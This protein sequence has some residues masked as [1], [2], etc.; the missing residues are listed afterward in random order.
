MKRSFNILW[1]L[2]LALSASFVSC[3]KDLEDEGVYAKTEY[4]GKVVEKSTMQPIANVAVQ[5]TDGTHIHASSY[6]DGA[7]NFDIKNI[8]FDEVSKNYYLWLDGSQINLPSKQEPLKGLGKKVYDYKTLIL[9]DKT[10][11]SIL[12]SVSTDAINS[13]KATTATVSG[14]VSSDGGYTVKERGI[15]YATTQTPTV[16]NIKVNAGT[17]KGSFTCNLSGLTKN[18]TYYVRAYAINSIGT[19]Y[20]AQKTFTT[21]SGVPTITTTTPSSVTA[22]SAVVGG[23]ISN[24]GGL[25]VTSRGV[26]YGTAPN[27]TVQGTR[28]TDGSGTGSFTHTVQ[29]LMINTTYYVRAYA[30]N[31]S[32]TTYGNQKTFTTLNGLPTLSTAAVT[33]ITGSSAKC[34]GT[35]TDNGGA[36]VSARGVCWNLTGNPTV[37]DGHTTDGSGNGVFTSNITGLTAGKTYHVR[38][39]ATNSNGTAYGSERTFTTTNGLPTLTTTEVTNITATSATSGGIITANGGAN[40]TA[41]GVCY[42][43][44]GNPTVSDGHTTNGTGNGT[45]TSN[46]SGLTAGTT[47][48]IRAYAT[49]SNGTA[50]GNVL[51]FSTSGGSVTLTTTTPSS[52][53]ATSAVSGGNI[54]NDGGSS[55]TERGLCWST[56]QYPV[57]TGSHLSIG[58]GT[59]SFSGSI[60]GLSTSTTYYVRAYAKNAT[61]TYYGSQK[62]FTTK[63]GM[64]TV[65]TS[66]ASNITATSFVCGGNVSSD[67]G[68]SVTARG[69]C[70]STIQYPTI[71]GSHNTLGSG[72]GTFT[73]SATGLTGNTTY[74]VRAYA[75]NSKGTSYGD[76]IT[77]M[78]VSGLPTVTT[79]D[80]TNA[81]T[82]SATTGGNVTSDGG[83]PVTARGVCYGR[84]PN[85]DLTSSFTH[86]NNGSGTGSFTSQ[87]NI[88]GDGTYYVRAYATNSNGTVYGAQKTVTINT[89]YLALP[90]FTYGGHTYKVAPDP[91]YGMTYPTAYSYCYGLSLG[92]YTDWS[93]P[94]Q[95]ELVM[96]YSNRTSIGGFMYDSWY[97]ATTGYSG[98]SYQPAIDFSSGDVSSVYATGNYYRVRPVRIDH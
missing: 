46:I 88:N 59:G 35:I 3:V 22:K 75:T 89:A 74:Y 44:T 19:V 18:T 2:L 56:S 31:G 16:G 83:Y 63:S 4:K 1:I 93:L 5:V 20:G 33:E 55:I 72:T 12:P 21:M 27:P 30:V 58:S 49:N 11:A 13:I 34:G 65:T 37:S 85:P 41:R 53:T 79:A 80:I 73:G 25:S 51:S 9:Y 66:T 15:C 28:T 86:T 90:T 70:W 84:M 68:F 40:V 47:Y 10:N 6:T 76:Q 43:T 29:G 94:S 54:T 26:C 77:V 98:N 17:G 67:G 91:G 48:Y 45:F 96:M 24:D 82:T 39:Y 97:W 32:G 52:I 50:Y 87:I 92:G 60:T 42:N 95:G 61:G 57:A 62:S 78:T 7:G 81:T 23:S 69:L 71:S 64:P 14:T 36:N 38:A 8:N